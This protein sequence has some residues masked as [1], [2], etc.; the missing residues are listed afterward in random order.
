MFELCD[1]E[2][3]KLKPETA[4]IVCANKTE[5]EK[6]LSERYILT[7]M[8]S[9]RFIQHKFGEDSFDSSAEMIWYAINGD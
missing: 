8:Q 9:K 5:S 1:P 3:N 2:K 4:G 6:W 7:V